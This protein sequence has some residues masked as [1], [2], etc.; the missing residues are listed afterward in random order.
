MTTSIFHFIVVNIALALFYICFKVLFEK[1]TFL[2]TKRMYLKYSFLFSL[3]LPLMN[4]SGWLEQPKIAQTIITSVVMLPEVSIAP[5]KSSFLWDMETVFVMAYVLVS[6]FF[7]ARFVVQ[8]FT[9]I[10]MR[11]KG[12]VTMIWDTKVIVLGQN[13]APFSFL[14][15]IFI[16]PDLHTEPELK[17][18]LAH[19]SIHVKQAHSGDVF[20]SELMIMC[21]W[22]N[23]FAWLMRREI[24][25]NLEFIADNKVIESGFDSKTYQYHLLKL[26]CQSPDIQLTN[27]F[28]VL[29]LKKR[30]TMMNKPKNFE[31]GIIEILAYCTTCIGFNTFEQCT[32][33][34]KKNEKSG[35]RCSRHDYCKSQQSKG[36]N[37][38]TTG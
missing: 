10:G 23:P 36:G 30:I 38:K 32:K 29:P 16:N 1:D 13:I 34:S 3:Y 11:K 37:S 31:S 4:I 17:E 18:I 14:N 6:L 24:R 27:N 9:I 2:R 35:Y 12:R 26:S 22:I 19:E 21:F 28:N 20:L 7:V 25:Q 15:W 33:C 8:L 5:A